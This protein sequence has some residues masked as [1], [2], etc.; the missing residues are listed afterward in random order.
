MRT[1]NILFSFALMTAMFAVLSCGGGGGGGSSTPGDVVKTAMENLADANY[2]AAIAVYVTKNGEE[3]SEKEKNKMKAFLPSAKE[4]LDK[5]GGIKEIQIIKEIIS[6]D[7]N[8]ATV[9]TQMI[10]GNGKKGQYK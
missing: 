9:K 3:L 1:L 7:G 6:E 5:N 2:D 8:T 4:D 10:Y